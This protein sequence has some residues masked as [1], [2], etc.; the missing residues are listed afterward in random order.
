MHPRYLVDNEPCEL[1]PKRIAGVQTL[2]TI[3]DMDHRVSLFWFDDN[4]AE[5]VINDETHLVFIAQDEDKL[6]IHLNGRTHCIERLND[7]SGSSGIQEV[8]GIITA[9][10]PGAVLTIHVKV[11]EPVTN[12]QV[13]MVIESMK[14]QLE[15]KSNTDG[16]ARAINYEVGQTFD[17]GVLLVDIE[18]KETCEE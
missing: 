7:F 11:G 8:D 1:A 2:I 3:D 13:L 10:M 12:D 9:P 16:I 18:A 17:R 14:M 15:I 4:Q 5:L 6:F